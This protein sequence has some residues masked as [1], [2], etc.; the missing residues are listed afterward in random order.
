MNEDNRCSQCGRFR[1]LEDLLLQMGE[2]NEEW[3]ECIDC[4]SPSDRAMVEG[5][6]KKTGLT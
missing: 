1:K 6:K 4:M 3:L 5:F 2:Y